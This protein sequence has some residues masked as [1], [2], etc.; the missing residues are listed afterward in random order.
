M[1][2]SPKIEKWFGVFFDTMDN[3]L[4]KYDIL[5]RIFSGFFPDFLQII[6]FHW[7]CPERYNEIFSGFSLNLQNLLM[8]IFHR[9]SHVVFC[10]I[11]IALNLFM[12]FRISKSLIKVYSAH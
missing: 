11:R 8:Y 5:F 4:I 9:I 6:I 10:K 3:L 12:S 1:S 2:E 7:F